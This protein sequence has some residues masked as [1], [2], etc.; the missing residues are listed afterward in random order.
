MQE[1]FECSNTH[2]SNQDDFGDLYCDDFILA[3]GCVAHWKLNWYTLD[4][5]QHA[6]LKRGLSKQHAGEDKLLGL[7]EQAMEYAAA[8]G[9]TV[10]YELCRLCDLTECQVGSNQVVVEMTLEKVNMKVDQAVEKMG[11]LEAWVENLSGQVLML[12]DMVLRMN[13]EQAWLVRIN[14]STT[15]ALHQSLVQIGNLVT[16]VAVLEHGPWNPVVIDDNSNGE[17]VVT[18]EM[19]RE[20]NEVL[21][22]IPPP[23][24]LVEIVNY[25]GEEFVSASGGLEE[26]L[27]I[28]RAQA[29]PAPEYE[30]APKYTE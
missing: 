20:E 13:E 23:G 15:E 24:Q 9:V 2:D 29:D 30:E 18:D 1:F 27:D 12:Q 3:M 25:D 11:E 28:V 6:F 19:V 16:R 5:Y 7:L 8:V 14:I 22:P 17:T 4:P 26:G 10:F 21:I